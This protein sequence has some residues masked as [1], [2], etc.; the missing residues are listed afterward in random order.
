MWRPKNGRNVSKLI[1]FET[2]L[3][4]NVSKF[5]ENTLEAEKVVK[6]AEI[7]EKWPSATFPSFYPLFG[8]CKGPHRAQITVKT[9]KFS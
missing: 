8:P 2:F 6:M 1:N 3:G 9:T 5:G 4:R 7:K